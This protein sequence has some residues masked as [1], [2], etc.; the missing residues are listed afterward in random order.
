MFCSGMIGLNLNNINFTKLFVPKRTP[1]PRCDTMLFLND[2]SFDT[3]QSSAKKHQTDKNTLKIYYYN[4]THGNSDSIAGIVSAAKNFKNANKD[5]PFFVLSAGDNVSGGDVEK[6]GFIEDIMQNIMGV[7][8]SAVGNHE[9]DAAS[10]GF[11]DTAT[12]RNI[13]FVAT[14]AEF[15]DDNKM[16]EFVKKSLVMERGG[17]KYGFVGTMPLDFTSCTKDNAQEGIK[18][19]DFDSTVKA[20]QKEIDN[21]KAQGIN[22]II[23]LAHTGYDTDKK[24]VQNLDGLDVVIGGH[25]HVVVDGAK[26]GENLLKSKSGEPVLITQAGENGKLYGIADIKFDD[27]GVIKDVSNTVY[28]SPLREKSPII[29]YIKSQ[30]LGK[31]PKIGVLKEADPLPENRRI[32]PCGWTLTMADAMKEELGTD[33]AIINSA[34]IRKVPKIGT[35]TERDVQESAPMKNRLIKAKITQKQLVDAVQN[36]ARQTLTTE[37]GCPGLI[38]GSGFGYKVDG[39]GNL[40][41]MNL[42]DKQGNKTPIDFKNPSDQITYLAA[43]DDFTAKADGE[44][45]ELA[46]KFGIDQKFDYDKDKTMCDYLLKMSNRENLKIVNDGRIQIQK[47]S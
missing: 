4:D 32:E 38:Q 45:P 17:V 39:K 20:L 36:A 42:I 34:N 29:E 11:Y 9:V 43:Y 22:R 3:F 46:P 25:T 16:N 18:V 40:L 30:N 8:A 2:I 5:K 31:S 6:N 44:T 47:T 37:E 12:K 28:A 15:D 27:K 19:L 21:L 10:G 35:L 14:N 1:V 41:E 13:K 26:E 24:L 23:M 7:D 33:I